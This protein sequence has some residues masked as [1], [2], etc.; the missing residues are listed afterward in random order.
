MNQTIVKAAITVLALSGVVSCTST[1]EAWSGFKPS[2]YVY[3]VTNGKDPEPLLKEQG[4][5]YYCEEGVIT[6]DKL[7]KACYVEKSLAQK[8]DEFTSSLADTPLA[9]AKDIIVIGKVTLTAIAVLFRGG[10]PS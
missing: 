5:K 6:S 1:Q 10:T 7:N 4:V 9:L 2:E 8:T 3:V